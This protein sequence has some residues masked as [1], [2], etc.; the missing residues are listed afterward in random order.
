MYSISNIESSFYGVNFAK[1][2][3]TDFKNYII[4]YQEIKKLEEINTI[5]KIA[6]KNSID[7]LNYVKKIT[8]K[9]N[10]KLKIS[11]Q[12]IHD[13]ALEYIIRAI[14]LNQTF[15]EN[16]K[17]YIN[18]L[19]VQQ[20]KEVN[21]WI[22]KNESLQ[23]FRILRNYTYHNTI[24][25]S[26]STMTWN[27]LLKKYEDIKVILLRNM[28]IDN[29]EKNGRDVKFI[30]ILKNNLDEEIN[31]V[32]YFEGWIKEINSLYKMILKFVSENLTD[33]IKIFNE[34]FYN[35]FISTNGYVVDIHENGTYD[36]YIIDKDIFRDI[37]NYI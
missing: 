19:N 30:N 22:Y 37:V 20:K 23:F 29:I 15:I 17:I 26:T 7:I 32:D 28:L 34:K 27:V 18:R 8:Q 33:N 3:D 36:K 14:L 31:L 2:N 35:S 25:I 24:P 5:K 11:H 12:E 16:V 1:M 6:I 9:L 10:N 21:S 13:V 4:I